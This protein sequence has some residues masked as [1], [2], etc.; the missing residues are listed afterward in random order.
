M[1]AQQT[2]APP[3]VPM[4]LSGDVPPIADPYF[5]RQE[6]GHGLA[7]GLR[8]GDV[9]VLTDDAS[10]SG[11]TGKTQLAVEFAHAM[12]NTAAA[13]V[14]I[15]VTASSH[16]AVVTGYAQAAV[17]V[18]AADADDQAETAASRLVSWLANIRRPW[19][20]I[21][22][23][24]AQVSDLDGLWP[25]GQSGLV[26]ITTRLAGPEI[27]AAAGR[28]VRV[29]AV[30]GFTRREALEYL[31]GRLTGYPDQRIEALDLGADLHGMPLALAQAAAV[32]VARGSDCREYR[33][34]LATRRAAMAAR[35]VQGLSPEL[36][37][38]WSIAAECA[39]QLPPDGLAWPALALAAMLDPH[40][41]PGAVLTSPTAC[42]Y[43]TGRP[44]TAG[45][46]DQNL[47]RRAIGNLAQAGLL[48]VDPASAVRT[49]RMHRSVQAAVRAW[50]PRAELEQVTLA[51]AD[52]LLETWPE[53][54]G[55][56]ELD[57][58]MRDGL[59]AL[60]EVD[61]A[62]LWK[63]DA[64][65]LLFRAGLSYQGSKLT[66]PSIAY[67]QAM[68]ATSTRLLGPAHASA[69]VARDRLASAYEAAD[70]AADAIAVFT[71]ALAD[72]ERNL[73]PEHPDTIAA[74]AR[75]AHAYAGAGR[76]E[77]LAIYERAVADSGRLL[78]PGHPGTLAARA[79]LTTAY[80]D[81]G[82]PADAVRSAQLLVT[83]TERLLGV[84]SPA[85]LAARVSLADA[86][87]ASG[88]T[89]DAIEQYKRVLT[90]HEMTSGPDNPDAI[91]AR[92]SL[93]SA[94][95]KGGKSKDAI[96]QYERVLADRMR[97][98]G[99]DHPDTITARANL[100]YGYRSA[101]Q[102][103][104][105]I[106]VYEQVLA[107]RERT[108]GPGHRDTRLARTNLAAAYQ[109]AG[110]HGDAVTQYERALTDSER[111]QGPGDMETLTD[112]CSLAAV[113]FAAGR[114]MEVITVLR[115]ALADCEHFLGP[116]HPMTRTVRENLGTATKV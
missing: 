101:G 21:I 69:V 76:P 108:Q 48:T 7:A 58:V 39:H 59:S 88:K 100:A 3:R 79:S 83:D 51:A 33:A 71:S 26:V 8:P 11:G 89:K 57:Q 109:Q 40:G 68:V 105:A 15:W 27:S 64:H 70:R 77:A 87:L 110:R 10:S 53:G 43:I 47:V 41:I 38:T 34:Q 61:G 17:T 25:G 93:A 50:I 19:A 44:S 36:L 49:V 103:R 54:E 67:W 56:V 55:A 116:D 60:L 96:V 85:A 13:D 72:R 99:P 5:P 62:M 81:A 115:R 90:A 63:P 45:G 23:D 20:L 73:G 2:G 1:V 80:L 42:G 29:L 86:H 82:R 9:V 6:T 14:L 35:S 22:D 92:A 112:R 24:L 114:L 102:L 18:G 28:E 75:L 16:E 95:R 66:E 113:L 4:L 32:I 74:R 12:W 65:P 106:P 46:A 84:N 111:M 31:N 98:A 52:A 107:D 91:D 78:G 37:A 30:Q 104:E 97:T 94:L